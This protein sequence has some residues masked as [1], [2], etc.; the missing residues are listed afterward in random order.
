ML[1]TKIR[2]FNI[3]S[4]N[5]ENG[6]FKSKINVNLPDLAFHQNH[7]QNVYMSVDHCEVPN[8][9][10]IVNY[11][12]NQIVIDNVT[13]IIPVGNYNV[14]SFITV[15]LA[16]IPS[17]FTITYDIITN[18]YTF[19]NN[20]IFTINGSNIN[21]TINKIIGLD[22]NDYESIPLGLSTELILPHMVNFLP[23]ARINF[24]SNFFNIN[25]YNSSDGSSDVF[26]PLQ[27]NTGQLSM[28]YYVNQTNTNFII[29]D[30]NITTININVTDDENNLINFNNV[31]CIMTF[32]IKVDYKDLNDPNNSFLTIVKNNNNINI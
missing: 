29:N 22:N 21:C 18:K 28:I 19:F 10:Y 7:I 32:T 14:N 8:S 16:V 1:K 6:S 11:T 27:N 15:C 13:Y 9:F 3:S 26:L 30:V 17:G 12:N 5:A 20:F 25:N 2:L 31:D 4:S 24:R 23:M